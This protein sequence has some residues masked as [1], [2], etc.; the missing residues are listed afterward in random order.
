MKFLAILTTLVAAVT[1][2]EELEIEV[3]KKIPTA[4]CRRKT[5]AGDL[6]A[7]HYRGTL[8]DGTEFYA[9]YNRGQPITFPLGAGNV[10]QGWD[11]G[12]LDMCVGEK[13]K[14][15]IPP[16]LGYGL[17]AMGPIPANSVLV[18]DTELVDIAGGYDE[19]I[20]NAEDRIEANEAVVDEL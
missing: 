15:V 14:L 4:A 17:R 18:F 3:T 5:K 8:E 16:H 9:S 11:Q 7:V 1:A 2:V 19:D 10:I 20:D 6:V 12:L 13:R